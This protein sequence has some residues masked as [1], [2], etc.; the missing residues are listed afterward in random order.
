MTRREGYEFLAAL[1]SGDPSVYLPLTAGAAREIFQ[2]ERDRVSEW[3]PALRND[4]FRI[5]SWRHL[6][7]EPHADG[8]LLLKLDKPEDRWDMTDG[9]QFELTCLQDP[10]SGESQWRLSRIGWGLWY[11][12]PPSPISGQDG[13]L[14]EDLALRLFRAAKLAFGQPRMVMYTAMAEKAL[15]RDRARHLAAGP[16]TVATPAERPQ[17]PGIGP[18]MRFVPGDENGTTDGIWLDEAGNPTGERVRYYRQDGL[19]KVAGHTVDGKWVQ[20]QEPKLEPVTLDRMFLGLKPG[21]TREE[22]AFLLP[23]DPVERQEVMDARGMTLGW[24]GDR[25]NSITARSGAT[26]RGMRVGDNYLSLYALYSADG[27]KTGERWLSYG[28][29][30]VVLRFHFRQGVGIIDEIVYEWDK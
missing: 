22:V 9:S 3:W 26:Y 8:T 21:M 18:F 10:N 27:T 16:M 11:D 13:P 30:N 17:W 7:M 14:T 28:D 4:D 23:R 25:L 24:S 20:P 12:P 15:G 6:T 2:F 5:A 1:S 29:G 19:W